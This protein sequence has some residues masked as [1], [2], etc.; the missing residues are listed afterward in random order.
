MLLSCYEAVIKQELMLLTTMYQFE[1]FF[2]PFYAVSM[3]FNK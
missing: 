3:R 1:A 2:T